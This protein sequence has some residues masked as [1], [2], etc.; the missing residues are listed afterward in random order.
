VV[1]QI[2]LRGESRGLKLVEIGSRLKSRVVSLGVVQRSIEISLILRFPA[3]GER[4]GLRW[5]H[6]SR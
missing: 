4:R 5:M 6:V 2:P 1:S 3:S